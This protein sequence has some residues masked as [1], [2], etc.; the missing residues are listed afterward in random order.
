MTWGELKK[1]AAQLGV[2]DSDQTGITQ[3]DR[4]GRAWLRVHGFLPIKGPIPMLPVK[5][6]TRGR[7][8]ITA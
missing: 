2:Q 1:R 3:I 8:T 7:K 5:E 6:K 4:Q